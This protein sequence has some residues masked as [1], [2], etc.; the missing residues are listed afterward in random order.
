MHTTKHQTM[1]IVPRD[2]F[3]AT[4]LSLSL[5][6]GCGRERSPLPQARRASE[7]RPLGQRDPQW[8]MPRMKERTKVHAHNL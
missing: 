3:D 1:S 7:I 5:W 2:G 6:V 8:Q 4:S